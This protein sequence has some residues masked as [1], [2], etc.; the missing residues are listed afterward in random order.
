MKC[1]SE[2]HGWVRC[3]NVEDDE[4]NAWVKENGNIKPCP[5]CR[6]NTWKYDGCNHIT[7]QKCHY[8]WCWVCFGKYNIPG[9][10][11]EGFFKCPGG[12]FGSAN[13]C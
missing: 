10:H 3:A 13:T 11:Y 12:Q 9:G 6:I 8:E 1:G 2:Y 7:C 4:F 5:Q